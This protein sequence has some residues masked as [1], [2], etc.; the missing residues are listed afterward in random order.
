MTYILKGHV[1]FDYQVPEGCTWVD[2]EFAPPQTGHSV[3]VRW[4]IAD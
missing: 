2:L 1:I 3:S 4:E